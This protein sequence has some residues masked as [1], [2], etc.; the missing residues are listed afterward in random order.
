MEKQG[1]KSTRKKKI[2]N[3][4]NILCF[5]VVTALGI[6]FVTADLDAT[7]LSGKV[8]KI[9]HHYAESSEREI[10]SSDDYKVDY[11]PPSVP[12]LTCAGIEFGDGSVIFADQV[13]GYTLFDPDHSMVDSIV[14]TD[15]IERDITIDCKKGVRFY[16]GNEDVNSFLCN[17][18]TIEVKEGKVYYDQSLVKYNDTAFSAYQLTEDYALECTYPGHYAVRKKDGTVTDRVSVK[19]DNGISV[20]IRA[21]DYG[22]QAVNNDGYI[23]LALKFNDDLLVTSYNDLKVYIN[24]EELVPPGYYDK[25][26][27]PEEPEELDSSSSSED[28]QEDPSSDDSEPK[29]PAISNAS[30]TPLAVMLSPAEHGYVNRDNADLSPYTTTLLELVNQTRRQYGLREVYGLTMLDTAAHTR[31]R[32]LT[33]SFSHQRPDESSYTTV[34]DENNILWWDCKEN[35]AMTEHPSVEEVLNL[36]MASDE[37]RAQL[38][39]KNIKYISVYAVLGSNDMYYWDLLA[40]YDIYIRE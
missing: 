35:I 13:G 17:G 1:K 25:Y 26:V 16:F 14:V 5:G 7:D 33:R 6:G 39:D 20:D 29:G 2:S 10:D 15:D 3:I 30:E 22:F 23:E 4:T 37:H 12:E 38:L 40:M 9:R 21:D 31:A 24:G 34:L 27:R 8:T 18:H 19:D 28:E 11:V 36:W 32:E